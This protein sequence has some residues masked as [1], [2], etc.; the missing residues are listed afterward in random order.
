MPDQGV[1][2]SPLAPLAGM[3][4][5]GAT[6]AGAGA[7]L[8]SLQLLRDDLNPSP[9]SKGSTEVLWLF[10]FSQETNNCK[11]SSLL[12]T[13]LLGAQREQEAVFT[14]QS[15]VQWPAFL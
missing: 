12:F 10:P 4:H 1:S 9:F 13:N 6:R 11:S 15:W 3:E 2:H 7:S 14:S 5:P 8:G